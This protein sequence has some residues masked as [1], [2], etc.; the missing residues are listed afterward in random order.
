MSQSRAGPCFDG[1]AALSWLTRRHFRLKENLFNVGAP[2]T[3][4][5]WPFDV[6]TCAGP[7]KGGEGIGAPQGVIGFDLLIGW[8]SGGA[9]TLGALRERSDR[10]GDR[11]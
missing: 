1:I 3:A 7:E 10:L 4:C 5:A 11:C 6:L 2:Q 9:E 8:K